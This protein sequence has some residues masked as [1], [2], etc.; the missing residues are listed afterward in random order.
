MH[1]FKAVPF[2]QT[3]PKNSFV[4]GMSDKEIKII[5]EMTFIKQAL[6]AERLFRDAGIRATN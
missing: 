4:V 3:D 5:T 2:K 6:F 1:C